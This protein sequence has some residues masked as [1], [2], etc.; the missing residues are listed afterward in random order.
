[1]FINDNHDCVLSYNQQQMPSFGHHHMNNYNNM[2]HRRERQPADNQLR[3]ASLTY[4][5]YNYLRVY[6]YILCVK[7]SFVIY[8][9]F[10]MK[11]TKLLINSFIS[12]TVRQYI[13]TIK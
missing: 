12:F 1:M 3:H 10:V 5:M 9:L 13:D 2:I 11:Y 8:F 4:R 7:C 6:K